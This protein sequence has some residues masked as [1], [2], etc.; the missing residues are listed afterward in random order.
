M[1]LLKELFKDIEVVAF[2]PE[3]A[4]EKYGNL[5]ISGIAEDS[6]KVKPGYIFV[7]KKG[8]RLNGE[9]FIEDA[10]ERGAIVVVKETPLK[11]SKK[12]K[13]VVFVQVK[14]VK[15]A[16]SI[17]TLNFFSHPEKRLLL[18]GVTGTNGKTSV[19]Y[20]TKTVLNKAGLKTGYMGTLFYETDRIIPALETTPSIIKIAEILD[21]MVKKGF[22]ACVMEVSSH[23]LDQDR[24]MGLLFDI[25]VFT[26]LSRDHLDYHKTMEDYYQAKKKLFTSYSKPEGKM[27]ISFETDYGKRLAEEIYYVGNRLITVNNDRIKAEILDREN[28][29]IFLLRLFKNSY[30]ISTTLYGDYQAKNIATLSGILLALGWEEEKIAY[31]LKGLKNPIGRLEL[32]AEHRGAKIF[33]DYAHTPSALEEALK[34]LESLK[35]GRLLLLFGCGGNRDKGKRPI[36]GKIASSFADVVFLT[37]DNPRFEDPLQII[38]DIKKGMNGKTP[39]IVIPD[40]KKAIEEAVKELK[41]GDVL[42][43]AGKGHETYQEIRG[44]RYHL[45]DQEEVIKAIKK[46]GD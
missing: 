22:D 25:T 20:F 17:L 10:I 12:F 34:S 39:C 44:K 8:T 13:D 38:E 5:E 27:V 18:I 23:A 42:L 21:E 28:G 19:S 15:K 9:D 40:R 1:K 46:G 7:A 41:K 3:S 29:L 30:K 31:Y 26:N 35:R 36:M 11:G 6:R 43:I 33:V 32:V 4:M 2:F 14:N 45:S 37:S 24:I 16:L